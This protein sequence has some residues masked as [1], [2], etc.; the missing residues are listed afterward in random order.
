MSIYLSPSFYSFYQKYI[1]SLKKILFFLKVL[2]TP[3]FFYRFS[4]FSTSIGSS[5][6]QTSDSDDQTSSTTEDAT[7]STSSEATSTTD[8]TTVQDSTTE[9]VK[10]DSNVSIFNKVP[11]L[12]V[13]N[14]RFYYPT[15]LSNKVFCQ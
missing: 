9:S 10:S 11:L 12:Q 2:L 7:T 4:T 14:S 5:S 8:A 15:I 13:T 1:N 6:E 3:Y